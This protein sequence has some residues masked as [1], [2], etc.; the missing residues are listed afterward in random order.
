MSNSVDFLLRPLSTL[1]GIGD[2]TA[3][4]F[5]KIG[6]NTK[7]DLLNHIP[8]RVEK[9]YFYPNLSEVPDRAQVVLNVEILSVN[10]SSSYATRGRHR[11][12]KIEASD[13]RD[14]IELM[15]FN[16]PAHYL[17]KRLVNGAKAIVSG[18]IERSGFG[19]Y[20]IIHPMVHNNV[21]EIAKLDIVYPLTA[22]LNSKLISKSVNYALINT[23]PIEEWIPDKILKDHSWSG[24]Y[25]AMSNVH[26]PSSEIDI[27]L[28]SANVKRLAFDELLASQIAIKI[29]RKNR[30]ILTKGKEVNFY[31]VLAMNVVKEAGFELTEGQKQAI[32]DI[33][34]D[35][36]EYYRMMRLV[37]G[38]VGSGKTIVA[39][40]AM[41]NVREDRMQ[42]VLMAPTE[43]L[44]K[45]HLHNIKKLVKN[46]DVVVEV[47]T[48]KT[49]KLK[50]RDILNRL[51]YGEIHIL[52]GTHAVFQPDVKFWNL[53][54]VVID[55]QH[56]FGVQQRMELMNKGDK[57]DVLIMSATP[58][59]RTLAMSIYGD[60]DISTIKD[61][62]A[63]RK[64]IDTRTI[65]ESREP[66]IID[67]IKRKI[68]L[69]EQVYWVCPLISS[70][71]NE[72][73]PDDTS[74]A[75]E[76]RY[77][78]LRKI[79]G[80]K[81]SLL[82]GKMSVEEKEAVMYEFVMGRKSVLV[83]TTVIEVGVN[84]P[85]ATL[86]VV[87]KAE[88]FGLS[89]L[90][91]LRG[92]VGRGDKQS[93]CILM[94]SKNISQTST[95]RLKTLKESEDGFYIAEQDF[96]I[97]G[98]GD[99][100]GAKQSGLPNYRVANFEYHSDLL[101][102]ASNVANEIVKNDRESEEKYKNLIKLFGY[103]EAK[104]YLHS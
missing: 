2:K 5:S 104:K 87:E 67:F 84:V 27:N 82:H 102:E 20:K 44:A 46:R 24:W 78:T 81:V 64:P 6:L 88:K 40:W 63:G 32:K 33:E 99:I 34:K 58:I 101:F 10:K 92:R 11:Y 13:G 79:F 76:T 100:L 75:A 55:E 45:Q 80:D 103:N 37:Q 97:R 4:I 14:N 1:P 53:G 89:Q 48:S 90:H 71:G 62:P 73:L 36:G 94:F 66:E 69:N 51:K 57:C 29:I 91:Q 35:Q 25:E 68:A 18:R 42:S 39:L 77:K 23:S 60:L 28:E 12:I 43:I 17:S 86:L 49:S 38:D 95:A 47:L 16:F 21:K 85:N 93:H 65:S 7:F 9:R 98:G 72:E 59:P 61:K 3:E 56:R 50:R 8:F 26:N 96:K 19:S 70:Q 31:G 52:I 15:Y 30:S 22:G 74:P 54:L 41:L 83:S